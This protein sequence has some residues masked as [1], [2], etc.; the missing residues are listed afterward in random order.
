M[1]AREHCYNKPT[2]AYASTLGGIEIKEIKYEYGDTRIYCIS[3]AW[4]G[5]RSFHGVR[6]NYTRTG[7][8][9][10]TLFGQRIHLDEC[11]R[12]N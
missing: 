10:F 9:Y 2:I 5:T 8:A 3:N 7:R 6:V 12:C 1:T 11:I 4:Y